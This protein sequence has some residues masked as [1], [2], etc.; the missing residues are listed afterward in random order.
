VLSMNGLPLPTSGLTFTTVM[1]KNTTASQQITL[2]NSGGTPVQWSAAAIAD[3][4]LSWL[5]INDGKTGGTLNISGTDRIGLSVS[6]NGLPSSTKPYR[7]SFILTVNRTQAIIPVSLTVQ[8]TS[9]EVVV[10]PNPVIAYLQGG[11][12]CQP[13]TLTLINLSSQIVTWNAN[14]YDMDKPHIHL[15]GLTTDQGTLDPEGQA[16]D[17][18][19]IQITCIGAQAGEKLYH[20]NVYYNGVAVN[21]PVSIRYAKI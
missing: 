4:N 3:N 14:P 17:T 21:V 6:T 12:T 16:T 13:A 8:D 5:V 11:G 15:D 7:G 18:K 20:I 19:V 9:L 10:N 1:D 2:T